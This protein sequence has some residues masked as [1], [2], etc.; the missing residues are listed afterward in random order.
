MKLLALVELPK[1]KRQVFTPKHLLLCSMGLTS[2][3]TERI[4]LRLSGIREWLG[5]GMFFFGLDGYISKRELQAEL[6]YSRVHH[7][8]YA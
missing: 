4:F 5:C 6:F 8:F 1:T 2:T 3:F 7:A